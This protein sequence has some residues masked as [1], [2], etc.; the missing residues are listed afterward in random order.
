MAS[1]AEEKQRRREERLAREEMA[2]HDERHKRLIGFAVAGVLVV[3]SIVA[4]VAV[5]TVG[6]GGESATGSEAAFGPH[7]DG[8]DDRRKVAGVPTMAEAQ[9]VGAE[10]FHPQIK[11]YANGKQLEVP[12]N[13]GIDPANPPADM[14][15]LHTHDDTGTIHNEAGT[16]SRLGQFFAVWGVPLSSKQLGPYRA[17]GSSTSEYGWTGSPPGTSASSSSGTDSRQ[18]SPTARSQTCRSSHLCELGSVSFRGAAGP[19]A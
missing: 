1:R 15:G 19:H 3:A 6:S 11:V 18:S 4:I 13:I 16:S 7:Y 10:H 14:A 12:P 2:R 5:V 9:T 8:L 17:T